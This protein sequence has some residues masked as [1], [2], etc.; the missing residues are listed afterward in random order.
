MGTSRVALKY[1]TRFRCLADKC[2]DT[3]CEGLNVDV[4]RLSYERLQQAVAGNATMQDKVTRLVVL[5]ASATGV[6]DHAMLQMDAAGCCGFL[7]E[8]KLCSLQ[9]TYGEQVLSDSCALF[10]R[11]ISQVDERIELSGSLACPEVARLCL[12]SDDSVG[13]VDIDASA[14]PRG[15]VGKQ[16]KKTKT[17]A[18]GFYLDDVRSLL[19]R[20]LTVSEYPLSLRMAA[21]AH[22]AH[23]IGEFYF[24][25]SPEFDKNWQ[26]CEKRMREEI[27]MIGQPELWTDMKEQFFGRRHFAA[28]ALAFVASALDSRLKLP[29]PERFK[30]LVS[31]VLA[32]YRGEAGK[33][34]EG[35]PADAMWEVYEQRYTLLSK[36]FGADLERL[37]HHYGFQYWFRDWYTAS[38]RLLD[39]AIKLLGRMG[40]IRFLIGG[41]PDVVK[42]AQ[43][44]ASAPAPSKEQ[45]DRFSR[46]MI[47]AVQ[48]FVKAV[49]HTP[50]YLRIVD[51]ALTSTEDPFSQALNFARLL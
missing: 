28:D 44:L 51:N 16:L 9:S 18:Y 10:P 48:G 8:K 3:C 7:D 46:A 14:Q 30:G 29:A 26:A 33:R 36:H 37:F 22:F 2:E 20:I 50:P 43:E 11:S 23:R 21:T 19:L 25:G 45:R 40:A 35:R 15:Y 42:L 38:D 31:S 4:D 12:L 17:D 41:H 39:H 32:H 13:I 47:E 1:M 5:N 34:G 49:E 27:E 6:R 24:R